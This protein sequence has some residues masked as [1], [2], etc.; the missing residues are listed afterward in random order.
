MK[1]CIHCGQPIRKRA[2]EM[3]ENQWFCYNCFRVGLREL[4]HPRHARRRIQWMRL[5]CLAS[6]FVIATACWLGVIALVRSCIHAA[7]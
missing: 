5:G 1:T 6:S 3:R 7:D 2:Y 4:A